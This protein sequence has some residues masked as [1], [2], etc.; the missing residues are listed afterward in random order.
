M[1]TQQRKCENFK[2]QALTL[3][4]LLPSP[5]TVLPSLLSLSTSTPLSLSAP[6]PCQPLHLSRYY[7]TNYMIYIP[8]LGP[9]YLLPLNA[10]NSSSVLSAK[11]F[12][13]TRNGRRARLWEKMNLE[14]KQNNKNQQ[15]TV[16][17]ETGGPM[18]QKHLSR[19]PQCGSPCFVVLSTRAMSMVTTT[20]EFR[21][22]FCLYRF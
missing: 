15:C 10:A 18:V 14:S 16:G 4:A 3:L 17:H 1:C 11:W 9:E 7:I 12:T 20:L 8:L 13:A 2:D 21:L 5:I 22:C 19:L 6:F